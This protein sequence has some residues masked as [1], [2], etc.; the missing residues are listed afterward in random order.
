MSITVRCE[1][2]VTPPA[3][4]AHFTT[5]LHTLLC[6]SGASGTADLGR[7]MGFETSCEAPW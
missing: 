3:K 6:I 1:G 7:G 5:A 2:P 4:K